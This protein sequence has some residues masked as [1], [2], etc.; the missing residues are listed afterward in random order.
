MISDVIKEHIQPLE[1]VRNQ[2]ISE[3]KQAKSKDLAREK[4]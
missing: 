1:E 3:V 4:S 2:I